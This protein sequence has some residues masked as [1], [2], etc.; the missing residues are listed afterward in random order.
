MILDIL[1]I[2]LFVIATLFGLLAL[3]R[4]NI[5]LRYIQHRQPGFVK[6]SGVLSASAMAAIFGVG[7]WL[8]L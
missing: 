5:N 8:V 4:V 1:A 7:G 2:A 6:W 3:I